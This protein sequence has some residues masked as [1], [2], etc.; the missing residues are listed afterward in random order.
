MQNKGIVTL[1]IFDNPMN[2]GILCGYLCMYPG[3]DTWPNIGFSDSKA[4]G[5]KMNG[6]RK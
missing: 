6:K 4:L 5:K 1:W 2:T 3:R